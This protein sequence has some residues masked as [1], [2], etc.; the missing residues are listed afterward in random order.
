MEKGLPAR[1]LRSFGLVTLGLAL[2]FVVPLW[3]LVRFAAGS[4]LYSYI[5]LVPFISLYLVWLKKTSSAAGFAPSPWPGS[6]IADV[7]D[8][9]A[10]CLL[11]LCPSAF[12]PDG[13]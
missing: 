1:R 11:A 3:N 12:E 7:R 9:G 13:G 5:L 8:R 10:H 4:E 6:G 2:G